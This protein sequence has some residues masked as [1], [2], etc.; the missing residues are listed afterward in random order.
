[1]II[2]EGETDIEFE[3][4]K[5]RCNDL[6]WQLINSFRNQIEIETDASV[7]Q[8]LQR[9]VDEAIEIHNEDS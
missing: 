9:L 3:E 2:R 7:K 8:E 1:M 4:R 6:F 5:H